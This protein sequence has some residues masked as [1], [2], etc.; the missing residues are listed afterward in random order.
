MSQGLFRAGSHIV[1]DTSFHHRPSQLTFVFNTVMKLKEIHRTSTFAWSPLS[2]PLLATG[3][4]AGALDESF[5]NDSQLEIWA[6][7]FLNK[8]E[9]DLGG[10]GQRGPRGSVANSSRCA[11]SYSSIMLDRMSPLVGS[12]ASPGGR[13]MVIAPKA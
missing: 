11:F 7:D 13:Q 4:V 10:E 3:T 1:R 6:P 9:Y 5:S 2:T 8:L 12:I